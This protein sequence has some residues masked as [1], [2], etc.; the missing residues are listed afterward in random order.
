MREI[1]FRAWIKDENRM[2]DPVIQ[3]N[4]QAQ[5]P[6]VA[7]YEDMHDALSGNLSDAFLDRV[8]LMQYTGLKDRNGKEIYEGEVIRIE[9]Y[10]DE[11]YEVVVEEKDGVPFC[12]RTPWSSEY[13]IMPLAWCINQFGTHTIEIIGNI[14][15]KPELLKDG[16][17]Q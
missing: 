7:W 13:D 8:E 1:K 4:F 9:P 15:E 11:Q 16:S 10:H 6:T 3:V 2:I 5:Y 17:A 14:Y 12:I